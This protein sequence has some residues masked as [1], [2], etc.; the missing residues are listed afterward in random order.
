MGQVPYRLREWVIENIFMVSP[1][2]YL[3]DGRQEWVSEALH[4]SKLRGAKSSQTNR[5][6]LKQPAIF[7][8]FVN[9]TFLLL[10]PDPYF[11]R[12]KLE[13]TFQVFF[14]KDQESTCVYTYESALL[15]GWNSTI[16]ISCFYTT[17]FPCQDSSEKMQTFLAE[18]ASCRTTWVF[19]H[20]ASSETEVRQY[21]R[22]GSGEE[23]AP[24]SRWGW[25]TV[26][27]RGG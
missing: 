12:T 17:W 1:L 6:P 18:L 4:S 2:C 5:F 13:A 27:I 23:D 15:G 8:G 25:G 22:T 21:R 10:Y 7:E 24:E 11:T 26:G 9:H 14:E 20:M 3:T 19:S 16:I